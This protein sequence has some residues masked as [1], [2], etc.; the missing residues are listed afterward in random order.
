MKVIVEINR[1]I[2]V[3]LIN[4]NE[5]KDALE[6]CKN[7]R[8]LIIESFL[9]IEECVDAIINLY[10]GGI[11]KVK[12]IR[13]E[14]KQKLHILGDLIIKDKDNCNRNKSLIR[15]PKML[16]EM[17]NRVA[18]N[19]KEIV[20]DQ[21]LKKFYKEL[22]SDDKEKLNNIIKRISGFE[23]DNFKGLPPKHQFGLLLIWYRALV[24]I[25][26]LNAGISLED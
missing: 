2:D 23:E 1:E 24:S 19:R 4:N 22:D 12:G 15:S 6:N 7:N 5:I 25:E 14:F 21:E 18:H 8:H 16:Q 26:Y 20:G 11:V 17:R 3:K 10:Y 13:L 9:I